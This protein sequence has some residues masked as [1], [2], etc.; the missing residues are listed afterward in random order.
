V[1]HLLAFVLC[2]AGFTALAFATRRQQRDII[3]R[4]LRVTT[5]YV[6][7]VVGA[8]A[9][10][11]ALGMLVSREGW[12]FGL[13]MFS[14]HTSLTAAIVYCALIGLVRRHARTLRRRPGSLRTP[15]SPA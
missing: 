14:G 4:P 2:L 3:G 1:T 15:S 6:L 11:L 7:R 9:L 12:S 13:V 5:T 8:C 10:L